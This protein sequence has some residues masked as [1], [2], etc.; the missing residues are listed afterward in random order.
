L[1]LFD[2]CEN[3]IDLEGKSPSFRLC[4]VFLK[5]IDLLSTK[6][7]PFSNRLFNP[8]S[9]RNSLPQKFKES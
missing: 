5:H 4:V 1:K 2:S 8:F 6:I 7:L 9:F 3:G